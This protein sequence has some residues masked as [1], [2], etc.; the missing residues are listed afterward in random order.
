MI[1][2]FNTNPLA[3]TIKYLVL[4]GDCVDGVG[5][6]PGQDKG[7][8]SSLY[9]QYSRLQSYWNFFLSGLSVLCP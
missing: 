2:W 6:Y 9:G 5:G 4:S 8:Q 3:R 7:C 1:Q